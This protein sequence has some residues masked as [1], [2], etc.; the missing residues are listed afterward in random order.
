[1][2]FRSSLQYAFK[3]RFGCGPMQWL[4]RQRLA[5]ARAMLMQA[6][7]PMA[8]KQVAQACGYLSQASFSRDF[9]ER[10]GERPSRLL[11]RSLGGLSSG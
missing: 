11:R 9:Q 2:L 10:Y 6:S 5:R 1:M 8:M 4:R 3:Q 7:Q